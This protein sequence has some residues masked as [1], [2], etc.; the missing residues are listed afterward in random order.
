MQG[1]M[2]LCLGLAAAC[3]AQVELHGSPASR[4]HHLHILLLAARVPGHF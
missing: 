3:L 4:A 1:W 2:H